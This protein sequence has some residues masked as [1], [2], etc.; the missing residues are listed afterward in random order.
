MPDGVANVAPVA[1]DPDA[2][3][4]A[5]SSGLAAATLGLD[6]ASLR[7]AEALARRHDL[8]T[9]PDAFALAAYDALRLG[10][11]ALRSAPGDSLASLRRTFVRLAARTTGITGPMK[12]NAAGD[13]AQ[14][15]YDFLGICPEGTAGTWAPLA[16]VSAAGA[17]TLSDACPEALARR[18]IGRF[19]RALQTGNGEALDA[20][21]A[22]EFQAVRA[23]GTV[24]TREEY[25]ASP[26]VVADYEFGP[27]TVTASEDTVV[28]SYTV[29]VDETLDGVLQPTAPAPRLSV[30]VRHGDTWYL[31]AH[32]NFGATN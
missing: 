13:R 14:G 17:V 2:A 28:A 3:A 6:G 12:L 5:V 29:T 21:L 7:R 25:L 10:V 24:L 18:V 1:S 11:R 30:L 23:N 4:A 15:D 27:F 31:S 22:P 19:F 8:E 32:A 9:V 26:A 16:H 20:V